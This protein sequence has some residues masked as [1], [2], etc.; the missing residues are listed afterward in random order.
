MADSLTPFPDLRELRAN[1]ARLARARVAVIGDHALDAYWDLDDAP[2]EWSQETGLATRTVRA[3]RYA[4]GGAANVVA[5]LCA[6]GACDV[7][8]IGV[9]GDDPFGRELARQ[10]AAV[11]ANTD[12]LVVDPGEQTLVFVKPIQSG[13]ELA[14]ID[15]GTHRAPGEVT[16]ARLVDCLRA[17]IG[18]GC[19][20]VVNQQVDTGLLARERAEV[21]RDALAQAPNRVVVDSRH[22]PL[23]FGPAV[24]KL[25]R[26]EAAAIESRRIDSIDEA[27]SLARELARRTANPVHLTM[28]ARGVLVAHG[29]S[30][31]HIRGVELP[32]PIDPV[33]CGDTFVAALA[34]ARCVGI[35][36]VE[37][38]RMANLAAAVTVQKTETTGT[39]T[40]GEIVDLARRFGPSTA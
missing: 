36:E 40:P 10:L 9:R 25:N 31:I 6:L 1:L 13:G 32:G 23:V 18:D 27:L 33:G 5:N 15:F 2:G 16:L 22:H 11:G 29:D 17:A 34:A 12:G 30:C 28:G 38:A 3:Q 8:V 14:R 20:I 24:L 37:A 35:G 19:A 21:F 4:P 26:K 39:A 7:R